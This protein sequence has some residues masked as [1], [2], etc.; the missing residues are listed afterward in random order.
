MK[1]TG[2]D[3]LPEESIEITG[4][5]EHNLKHVN[6]AIPK[7]KLV[8]FSG[9][10]GSGKSSLAFDTIYAEGR[11]RY[12]ES[13]SSYARQF[14]GQVE[15]P[16]YETIRGLAPTIAIEQKK[17]SS[18]PRSTVGTITEISDYLRVLY[19]RAA[20]QYC[21]QCG[22]PAGKISTE[23][24]IEGILSRHMGKQ[25]TILAP[26]ISSR[27]GEHKDVLGE[28]KHSGF[29]RVRH[30]GVITQIDDLK[31]DAKRKH[32][33]EVVIDRITVKQEERS[34]LSES[35]E[36]GLQVGEGWIKIVEGKDSEEVF[37]T[38]RSCAS[39]GIGLPEPSPPLFSFNSPLGMCKE[40]EGLGVK[41][42]AA[43]EKVVPDTTLS[44]EDGAV[45]PW[46]SLLEH[47]SFT[48]QYIM[49]LVDSLKISIKTPWRELPEPA[50]RVILYGSRERISM[51]IVTDRG[52]WNTR[53]SIEGVLK[54]VARLYRDT[55][56]EEM[57]F[58]YLKY[59][60]E[61]PC[62]GCGGTRL[63]P[64]AR[65]F[66][67]AGKSIDEVSALT[68][69]ASDEFFAGMKFEG[70]RAMVATEP[71]KEIRN[72]LHFLLNVGLNYLSLDRSGPTLS[73]GESQRIRLA[74]Q[75]GAELS[76][77]IY[78]LDE[79]SVGM[80]PR[81]IQRLLETLKRLRDLG[82]TVIVVEHD[83][84]TIE[85]SDWVAEF[86]PGAGR[87]GGE[88]VFYGTP[89]ELLNSDTLTAKYLTDRLEIQA[90]AKRLLPNSLS[91]SLKGCRKNNL[92][93]ID[94]EF[95]LGLFI[96][97]TGVSG[98]GKSSLV[99]ETLLPSLEAQ[100]RGERFDGRFLDSIEGA[101]NL[102]KIIAID[103]EPIGRTPRSNPAT[104]TKL[105]DPIRTLY[106]QSKESQLRGYSPGRFSFN[107]KGGR[108]EACDG[109][110]YI[111]V[112][113]HFLPDVYV[114]CEVCRG[115]RFNKETLKVRFKGLSIAE[116]LEMTVDD[117]V[118]VFSSFRA[119]SRVLKTLQRVG[120][121]YIQLGQPSTTLSGGEAQ[122]IKLARE[123]ARP[124]SGR[125][126]Y[127]LDEPTT[128]LHFDNIRMLVEVLREFVSRGN[129]VVVIEHNLDVIKCADWV[130]DLGPEG[131]A[132]GGEIVATGSPEDLADRGETETA[133]CLRPILHTLFT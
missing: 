40:C 9:V 30:N 22:K 125:T 89:A 49:A 18:N 81:D 73:G 63:R 106:A 65:A 16:R 26:L 103:Q 47:D 115:N 39:C 72:R 80:H 56:S 50:R 8:V 90:P 67:L 123:L 75:L 108:C 32:T 126:L 66:K 2:K 114:P 64:E 29:T 102:D 120:L 46:R 31:L 92:K 117:A 21:H 24:I 7:K 86:G 93:S 107:V 1:S 27:K 48:G 132:G 79:P 5:S 91:L 104:Y 87:H 3:P 15:K 82:N 118:E 13:L 127:V 45:V 33:I 10:S 77:V 43:E 119:I 55:A 109:N 85:Q 122:R 42:E 99:N 74:S 51:R 20:D 38:D 59:M 113:M 124:G 88:V 111:R 76:G 6:V 58:G 36:M 12:V 116:V 68:V 54:R 37:S 83:R 129:T 130:I 44:I 78:V 62:P 112:E 69:A 28:L 25:L 19:A 53:M 101:E 35:I 23:E 110:G 98:A 71:V 128:G 70:G 11:R 95:P 131:G 94:A 133:R 105:F 14:L 57:R 61:R 17:A 96:A 97:V 60:S 84:A 52:S 4:A 100:L 121:G 41:L 34:R